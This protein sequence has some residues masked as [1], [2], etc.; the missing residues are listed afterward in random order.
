MEANVYE[1]DPVKSPV[2][3]DM[4]LSYQIGGTA[5]ELAKKLNISPA[6]A[7]DVF[8]ESETC[9]MLHDKS[10]GLY[11]MSNKYLADEFVLE[12]QRGRVRKREK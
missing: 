12:C 7:L 5:A 9:E 4:I 8:Y 11:L 3:Q 10:T 2:I 6:Q 1:N